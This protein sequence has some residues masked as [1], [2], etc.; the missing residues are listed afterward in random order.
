MVQGKQLPS[1]LQSA[2]RRLVIQLSPR[3]GRTISP[4]TKRIRPLIRGPQPGQRQERS[5]HPRNWEYC[6]TRRQETKDIPNPNTKPTN[7]PTRRRIRNQVGREKRSRRLV[8]IC[9]STR[10]PPPTPLPH[11][12]HFP[13]P[14]Q[15]K[16]PHPTQQKKDPPDENNF[17][18]VKFSS[19]RRMS[20]L[21]NTRRR[22]RTIM[23]IGKTG[24]GKTTLINSMMNYLYGVK[25]SHP[26]RYRLIKEKK[27]EDGESSTP[28]LQSYYIQPPGIP[29]GLTIID[30]PGFSD[31]K[32]FSRDKQLIRDIKELFENRMETIDAVCFVL[33]SSLPRLTDDMRFVI[34]SVLGLFGK[35]ISENIILLMTFCDAQDPPFCSFLF[36]FSLLFR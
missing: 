7:R 28:K 24:H 3:H 30:T 34:D 16:K 4:F 2:E 26:F 1:L 9:R 20:S 18:Q 29:Y 36:I 32:G 15:Q 21:D 35:D 25:L 12:P 31:T 10:S 11:S 13:T 23:M 19:K 5:I 22:H 8:I 14:H 17:I 33:N 6:S 27:V